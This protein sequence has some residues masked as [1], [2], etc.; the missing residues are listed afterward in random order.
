MFFRILLY[1]TIAGSL[2]ATIISL[3]AI[4]GSYSLEGITIRGHERNLANGLNEGEYVGYQNNALVL[5]KILRGVLA[6]IAVSSGFVLS[7]LI[8][9]VRKINR[10]SR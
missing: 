9:S 2:A 6:Y 5:L 7:I 1:V 10:L 8:V 4:S 3:M